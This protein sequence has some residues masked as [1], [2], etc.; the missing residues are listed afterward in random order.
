MK[1]PKYEQKTFN[2]NLQKYNVRHII[3][4]CP[5]DIIRIQIINS[6]ESEVCVMIETKRTIVTE[7]RMAAL[8]SEF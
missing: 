4:L 5:A 2:M 6:E 7:Y 3:N 1:P 8:G